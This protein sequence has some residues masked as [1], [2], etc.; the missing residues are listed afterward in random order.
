MKAVGNE[1]LVKLLDGFDDRSA[2]AQCVLSFSLG[3][4]HE[5]KVIKL[6]T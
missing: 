5:I 6:Q 3:K 1:G 2:Y 4:G